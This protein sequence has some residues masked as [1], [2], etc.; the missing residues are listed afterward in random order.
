MAARRKTTK[1]R[2]TKKSSKKKTTVPAVRHL[3]YQ[4]T[5]PAP[6][7]IHQFYFDLFSHLSLVNRR[8]Y[9]QGQQLFIKKI[10]V[11]SRNT[12]NGSVTA[13]A[14]PTSWITYAAWKQ[15]FKLWM[16][17]RKGHGG[18]PGSGLPRSITPATW[19][20][21]KVYLSEEH[22]V[23]TAHWPLPLDSNNVAVITN[24]SEWVYSKF[25][26]PDA[27][28]GADEF[29]AHLLGPDTGA[30]GAI[31]SAAI[32]QGFKESRRTVQQDDSG[33][34]ID[35]TSWMVQLFDD[36]TTL[37]EIAA[38]LAQ[39][40]DLPPYDLDTYTGGASNMPTTIVQ[41]H[42]SVVQEGPALSA[43]TATLGSVLAPCGLLQ[44]DIQSNLEDDVWD[45]LI[46][47]QEGPNKGVKALPM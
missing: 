27:T 41:Q 36:G 22:R 23:G 21:F 42:K 6:G 35:S 9:R 47:I 8:L 38:D 12:T 29:T 44:L 26:S 33:D 5:T 31:T 11:N 46:E 16:E 7:A 4:V 40:G 25:I 24:T 17:M 14:A 20:D 30:A 28:A 32:I 3:K 37:D 10:T 39:D 34:E 1:R 2:T 15:A 43:P 19:A 45:I 13:S 18:A